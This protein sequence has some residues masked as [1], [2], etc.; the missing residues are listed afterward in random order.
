MKKKWILVLAFCLAL[1][2]L[3]AKDGGEY[4]APFCTRRGHDFDSRRI[5]Y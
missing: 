2:S 5:D 1:C 3:A 4:V